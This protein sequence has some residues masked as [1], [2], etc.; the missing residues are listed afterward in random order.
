M[1]SIVFL[2]IENNIRSARA[3]AVEHPHHLLYHIAFEDGYENIFF[4][5]VENG[6]WMEEDLGE[7]ELAA[8]VGAAISQ[9]RY[10]L[11]GPFKPLSWCRATI[12]GMVINFG[13]HTYRENSNTVFEIY[14]DNHKFLCNLVKDKKE[15]W[16]MY[17]AYRPSMEHQ[18]TNQLQVI[19]SLF[20]GMADARQ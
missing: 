16:M 6:S 20:E 7:T 18:Y 11:P 1:E 15:R 4:T 3:T 17:G 13:F 19:I 10:H 9:L 12:A 14:T 8:T 2:Q 5:D